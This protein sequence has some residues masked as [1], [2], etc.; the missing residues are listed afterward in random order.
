V[1]AHPDVLKMP[2][3]EFDALLNEATHPRPPHHASDTQ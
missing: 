3:S 2:R 1:D